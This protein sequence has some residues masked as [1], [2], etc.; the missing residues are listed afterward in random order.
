MAGNLK[1]V[2]DLKAAIAAS[3]PRGITKQDLED[4]LQSLDK[5][6]GTLSLKG[7]ETPLLLNAGWNRL[8]VFTASRDTQGVRDGLADELD[9]GSWF[10]IRPIAAGDYTLSANLRF[11]ADLAGTYQVRVGIRSGVDGTTS[12]ATYQD[13]ETLEAGEKAQ[14]ILS[15]VLV[16]DLGKG[17]RIYLEMKGTNG[18][19]VTATNGQFGVAR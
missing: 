10:D 13:A 1:S 5:V 17:D 8:D 19:S 11:T 4:I 9:P 15:S 2:S 14:F 18:A 6:G 16:K 12:S 3:G 7:G